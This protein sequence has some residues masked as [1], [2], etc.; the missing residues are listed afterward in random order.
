MKTNKFFNILASALSVLF[1]SACAGIEP[2]VGPNGGDNSELFPE[3]VVN[4]HLVAGDVFEMSFTP[5]ADWEVSVPQETITWFSIEDRGVKGN[6]KISGKA[7][8]ACNLKIN[9]SA[10]EL[11]QVKSCDVTMTANGESRVIAKLTRIAETTELVAYS[12]L[13]ENE[14]FVYDSSTESFTFEEAETKE[15]ALIKPYGG[16][17][18]RTYLR[19]KASAP[20]VISLPEWAEVFDVPE[21]FV[22]S[23]DIRIIGKDS[24][25]PLDG[26]SGK[27]TFHAKAN[28]DSK[29]ALIKEYDITIPGCRNVLEVG[30]ELN[31][32]LDGIHFNY[33]GK[34]R[35]EAGG[36]VEEPFTSTFTG[37]RAART[38]AIELVNGKYQEASWVKLSESSWNSE[39]GSPV[40]QERNIS[41]TV[42]KNNGEERKAVLVVLPAT[43]E[44]KDIFD[45]N[46]GI[47]SGEAI[48]EGFFHV[49]II[50]EPYID[51]ANLDFMEMIASPSDLASVGVA[52]ENADSKNETFTSFKADEAF[53]LTYTRDW[54]QDNGFFF[55]NKEFTG[56]KVYDESKHEVTSEGHWLSLESSE[57]NY[58]V[59]M[60]P[61]EVRQE[62][63]IVFYTQQ[64][65]GGITMAA[66]NVAVVHCIFDPAAEIDPGVTGIKFTPESANVA[67]MAGAK[68]TDYTNG[69][70]EHPYYKDNAEY[71]CPIYHLLYTMQD[72]P[73]SL[74]IPSGITLYTINPWSST[75]AFRVND[76]NHEETA[77][78]L[79][80]DGSVTI[81]MEPIEEGQEVSEATI[82]FYGGSGSADVKLALVCT[83][84]LSG[85]N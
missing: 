19:V 51:P 14:N 74:F 45:A 43:M 72:M 44:G 11:N 67:E 31:S 73:L 58:R 57:G 68:L 41:I 55:I 84:D 65:V 77:G 9:V 12:V 80:Y 46:D 54:S 39:A 59:I 10:K 52:F 61:S 27:V 69:P 48:K 34:L 35:N 20:W 25:L 1:I 22:E 24:K 33:V 75:K 82:L 78:K 49:D 64:K 26:A 42:D 15:I 66:K 32:S 4:D 50:Q 30:H 62:G 18:F 3:V 7:G 81:Y 29:G 6:Y 17:D 40:L 70:V 2:E 16:S 38:V 21:A 83:L 79:D 60:T 71:G 53:T 5:S 23:A 37:P 36:Y 85:T 28:G 76:L 47:I 13:V 63:Y 56:Y 8:Q